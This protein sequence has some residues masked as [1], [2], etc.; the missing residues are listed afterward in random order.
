MKLHDTMKIARWEFIKNIKSPTFLALT[1]IIPVLMV[2]G[3]MIGYFATSS[4]MNEIQQV[5]VIDETG[6]LFPILDAY[7]S[8]TPVEATL[9]TVDEREQVAEEVRQGLYNGYLYLT[10]QTVKSGEIPYYVKDTRDQNTFVLA[11]AVRYTVNLHRLQTAGLSDAAVR[12]ATAP[13]I[14][15]TRSLAGEEASLAEMLV[16]YAVVF[17]LVLAAMFSGQVLM[18]GVIKEK[19]NRIVEILLSSISSLDLLVGKL[20]GFAGLGLM[21]V[22]LWLAVGL[23]IAARFIDLGQISLTAADLVPAVLFFIGGYLLFASLFAAM[24]A[25]MKDAEGGSQM[26]G[27]VI[28]IPMIPLFA[29]QAIMMAPNALWVR[30]MSFVPPFIPVTVLIR[31]A[32]TTLPWWEIAATFVMLVLSAAVFVVLGARLFDRG[33]LHFERNLSFKDIGKMLKKNY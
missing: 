32:A 3:G 27:M 4:A 10:A 24:G 30:I 2:A 8:A 6:A 12:L 19:R 15:Q 14:F 25:T 29:A 1:I 9:F 31:M 33:I 16:P 22:A 17:I 28:L 21:Q 5:A 11:D 26:Q 23:T 13:I 7:L 20:I 18:Y